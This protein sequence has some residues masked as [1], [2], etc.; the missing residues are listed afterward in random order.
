MIDTSNL[1]PAR[2]S[3]APFGI[4]SLTRQGGITNR[5][6]LPASSSSD[7][8]EDLNSTGGRLPFDKF[9]HTESTSVNAMVNS[10][11]KP[12]V[13]PVSIKP[14]IALEKPHLPSKPLSSAFNKENVSTG[15]DAIGMHYPTIFII[16]QFAT[17]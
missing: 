2:H 12:I 3:M 10:A 4:H 9:E 14:Q 5:G 8:L 13:P 15:N 6:D 7:N 17:L 11:I 1:K 16:I